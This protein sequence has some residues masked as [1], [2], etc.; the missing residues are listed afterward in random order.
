MSQ[1]NNR[2]YYLMRAANSHD[3]ARRAVNP[4]IAAIH[5]ELARRYEILAVQPDKRNGGAMLATYAT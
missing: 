1:I 3:M 4:N 2:E 5:E